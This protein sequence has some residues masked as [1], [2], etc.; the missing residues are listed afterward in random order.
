M[1]TEIEFRLPKEGAC[2]R[3]L[4]NKKLGEIDKFVSRPFH[5]IL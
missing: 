2:T 4:T 5:F 3:G 1:A